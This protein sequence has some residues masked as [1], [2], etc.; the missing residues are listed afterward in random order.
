VF[1]DF[2][3]TVKVKP[4][5]VFQKIFLFPSVAERSRLRAS[6]FFEKTLTVLNPTPYSPRNKKTTDAMDEAE[7][8]KNVMDYGKQHKNIETKKLPPLRF[9]HKFRVGVSGFSSS[10]RTCA[11]LWFNYL[12][13]N[14]D[15][16][17][18]QNFEACIAGFRT[19]CITFLFRFFYCD[20]G[21]NYLVLNLLVHLLYHKL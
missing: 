12:G 4:Q 1:T 2:S 14:R 9:Q 18:L 3:R 8:K 5:A 21:F 10:F 13:S 11:R 19:A 7:V 20:N 16:S 6:V 17:R 15:L